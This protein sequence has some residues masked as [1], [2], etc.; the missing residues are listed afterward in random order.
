MSS[1]T[2]RQKCLAC[3][4]HA[5]TFPVLLSLLAQPI[6]T[7][8]FPW[9]EPLQP[10][11]LRP[12]IEAFIP[13]GLSHGR[14]DPAPPWQKRPVRCLY[15]PFFHNSA[16]EAPA[17]KW[18]QA[19]RLR[20]GAVSEGKESWGGGVRLGLGGVQDGGGFGMECVQG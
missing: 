2:P 9:R 1:I 3:G 13:H 5:C 19:E 15:T 17:E 10:P 14:A 16:Q 18:V 11:F 4:S 20:N 6:Y 12:L 8:L 7:H